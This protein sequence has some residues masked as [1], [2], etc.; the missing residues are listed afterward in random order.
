MR[1]ENPQV[2]LSTYAYS[3]YREPPTDVKL[4]PGMVVGIVHSY[5]D[6][7]GWSKWHEA[8]AELVL[9]PNWWHMGGSGP[10]LPLHAQGDYF[11]YAQAH[12]MI[13]FDFDS[14]VGQ[15]GN[16][17]ALYY[18][19]ARLSARPELMV[20]QVIDEYTSAFGAAAPVIRDYL[21]YWEAVTRRVASPVP[22]GGD[23]PQDS[24]GLFETLAREHGITGSTLASS[25]SMMPY[26]YTDEVIAPARALLQRAET[27][28]ANEPGLASRRVRYL[29]TA[30]ELLREHREVIRL[31][32]RKRRGAKE[33]DA[34]L[35][36]QMT[37]FEA[38]RTRA[39]AEFGP[40]G[41]D[42]TLPSRLN[43]KDPRKLDGL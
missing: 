24:N 23:V 28:V 6:T 34:D 13:G 26:I 8:G 35:K 37:S 17:G 27:A 36:R 19:I 1:A 14:L 38:M 41:F 2:T 29:E 11:R 12:A 5:A 25:W 40:I 21:D 3:C 31:A 39:I 32:D 20:D 15:W 43:I 30:L 22:A 9:R 33:T 4:G 16:Q 7:A 18:L 10:H 42:Q